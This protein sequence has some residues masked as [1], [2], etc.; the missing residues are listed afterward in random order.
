MLE[1]EELIYAEAL[2][3]VLRDFNIIQ[4][5]PSEEE[6][7]LKMVEERLKITDETTGDHEQHGLFIYQDPILSNRI[8]DIIGLAYIFRPIF[9]NGTATVK[10]KNLVTGKNESMRMQIDS[11]N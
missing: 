6:I 1:F 8:E 10:I 5:S 4:G 11:V 3:K 9:S 2:I 7:A